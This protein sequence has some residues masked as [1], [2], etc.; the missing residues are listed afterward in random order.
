MTL[1]TLPNEW[2]AD[3]LAAYRKRRYMMTYSRLRRWQP[4]IT[5]PADWSA[6]ITATEALRDDLAVAWGSADGREYEEDAGLDTL[7]T[8]AGLD[9]YQSGT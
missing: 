4:F 1:P 8:A 2:T 3:E 9:D 5:D 6:Y 7:I